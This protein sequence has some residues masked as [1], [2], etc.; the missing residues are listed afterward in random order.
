M[1]ELTGFPSGLAVEVREFSVGDRDAMLAERERPGPR[2]VE[3]AAAEERPMEPI[4]RVLQSTWVRTIDPAHY[5]FSD[6]RFDIRKLLDGDRWYFLLQ[7]RLMTWGKIAHMPLICRRKH[8]W[9]HAFDLSLA[10]ILTIRPEVAKALA[11]GQPLE[12]LLPRSQRRIWFRLLDGEIGDRI[13]E[14]IE[15]YPMDPETV[16]LAARIVKVDGW[17]DKTGL[18]AKTGL[19]LK[20]WV[21]QLPMADDEAFRDHLEAVEPG[22]DFE[23]D[24]ACPACGLVVPVDA[25][26]APDFFPTRRQRRRRMRPKS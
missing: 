7:H 14:D 16:A 6:G 1:P 20:T 23:A 2:T 12:F 5:K 24:V 25:T 17:D 22:V 21:K 4:T 11:G 18:D 15:A 9:E 3:Q 8:A 13:A 26:D 19:D 10:P